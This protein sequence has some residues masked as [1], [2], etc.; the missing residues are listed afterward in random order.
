VSAVDV[1]VP[2]GALLIGGER[3]DGP[4]L[5]W[6]HHVNPATGRPLGSFVMAD[7]AAV[8]AAVGAARQ[9]F[10]AWRDVPPAPRRDL[11]LELARLV[12]EHDAEFGTLRTLEL[13]APLKRKRGRSMAAEYIAYYAGWVD[14][15]EGRTV[16]VGPA[17]LDYTLPEPYGVVAVIIPWNGPVVSAGMKVAP[18]IAAGNCVVLKPSELGPLS[19]LRFGELCLEAGIPPGVVNVVPGGPAAG[20]RLVRHPD[21]AKVSFTGGLL[22]ARRI[23]AAVAERLTPVVM[24]L[25]GKSANIVFADA[26]LDRAVS[27][28]VATGLVNLSG[29]GCVLPTRLL[30]QDT[31]YADVERRVADMVAAVRVGDPFDPAI[32]MGPVIDAAACDRILGVIDR[33]RH[34]AGR[35]L[36]GGHRIEGELAG[37]YFIEPTVF[38][39]VD[40]A[41]A[42]AQDEVFGPVLSLIR[43][44]DDDEAVALAND[45]RYGLGGFVFTRN[46]E[47]GHRVAAGLD[48]GYVGVNGFPPMPPGAPFG[49]VKQ[50]GFGREGGEAG[51]REFVQEKNVYVDLGGA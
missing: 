47:R 31:V 25:G 30:V 5:A 26:D 7:E 40:N 43:F 20:E 6:R 10:P 8:D 28:G 33:A 24:E 11:L 45:T 36:T 2:S 48:A 22:T 19:A 17:A 1:A 13:G 9:A 15:L 27:I 42:L 29:Q 51:I 4:G 38:T 32:T 37:G 18:A 35:L 39:E 16:P 50:S 3:V 12:Q 34:E 14:K 49:G 44:S 46:L 41:S 21:V 23:M